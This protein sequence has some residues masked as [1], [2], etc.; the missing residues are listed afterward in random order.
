MFL[1]EVHSHGNM[2][3]GGGGGNIFL[4]EVLSHGNT[5]GRSQKMWS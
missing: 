3:G 1:N 5:K 4:N 2:K